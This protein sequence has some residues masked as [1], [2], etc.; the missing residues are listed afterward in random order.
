MQE[1]KRGSQH[2]PLPQL[3]LLFRLRILPLDAINRN[4]ARLLDHHLLPL[5][6]AEPPQHVE[7]VR[8]AQR[9]ERLGR[10][11]PAHG[12]LP[13]VLQHARQVPDRGVVARLAKAVGQLVLEQRRRRREARRDRVDGRPRLGARRLVLLRDVLERE[14]R[15]E[16]HGQ[17]RRLGAEALAEALDCREDVW[18]C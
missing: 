2:A 5:P 9:P 18:L 14:E 16:A 11:V 3:L 17:R 7:A 15:A 12:V 6:V 1:R 13:Q 8:A 10:L 4:L